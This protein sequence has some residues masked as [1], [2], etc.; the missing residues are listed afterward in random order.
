MSSNLV[1]RER[2]KNVSVQ[3]PNHNS[4]GLGLQTLSMQSIP[5]TTCCEFESSS[6]RGVHDTTLYVIVCQ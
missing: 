2:T 1:E 3:K 5:I 4:V 6:W